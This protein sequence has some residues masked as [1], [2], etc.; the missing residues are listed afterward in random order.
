[1]KKLIFILALV[2][3][4][5]NAYSETGKDVLLSVAKAMNY[6]KL[7]E[8]KNT[9][10]VIE[11]KINGVTVDIILLQKGKDKIRMEYN[12]MNMKQII[13]KNGDV[14]A[15]ISP[16]VKDLSS[17]DWMKMF[18]QSNSEN[19]SPLSFLDDTNKIIELKG[20][21]EYNGKSCKKIEIKEKKA[22]N[23]DVDKFYIFVDAI[24]NW[25]VGTKTEFKNKGTVDITFSDMKKIKGF[26]YPALFKTKTN[27]QE[28]L[29]MTI[30]SYEVNINLD[31]KLFE[32]P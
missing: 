29:T 20:I 3:I 28:T 27:G 24:T 22:V 2:F 11:L 9:K 32:K 12:M 5:N 8:F 17:D 30:K 6:E 14:C 1:M 10:K 7:K 4:Y 19:F 26:V 25:I 13:I 15:M 16:I 23:K 31:D 21:E 18:S